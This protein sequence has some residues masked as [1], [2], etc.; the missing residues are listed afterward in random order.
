MGFFHSKKGGTIRLSLDCASKT[1]ADRFLCRTMP[2]AGGSEWATLW[3]IDALENNKFPYFSWFDRNNLLFAAPAPLP[4]GSDIP[5][6][7]YSVYHAFDEECDRVYGPSPVVGQTV[8][9]RFGRLLR[10]TR[11]AVVRNDLRYSDTFGGSYVVWQLVRTPF[12][13]C[14][15]CYGAAY[16]PEK[17]QRFIQCLLSPPMQTTATRRSDTRYVTRGRGCEV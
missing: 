2:K 1:N 15:Y 6:G 16:G 12:K 13:N 17:L 7:W 8:Y 14:T 4:A 9:G 5:P 3:I 11:R 10:G